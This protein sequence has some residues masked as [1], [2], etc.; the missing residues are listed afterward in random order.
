[1]RFASQPNGIAN[2][3]NQLYAVLVYGTVSTLSMALSILLVCDILSPQ[4]RELVVLSLV[5]HLN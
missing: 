5:L 4:K 3:A 1:M 2:L